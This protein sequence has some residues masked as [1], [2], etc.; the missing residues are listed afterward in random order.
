MSKIDTIGEYYG[1]KVESAEI[2]DNRLNITFDDGVDI[3][4]WDNG[5]SCCEERYIT[6]DDDVSSLVGGVLTDISVSD[7]TESGGDYDVHEIA[8]VKVV[9]DRFAITL[10]THNIHNGYYGGFGLTITENK[11]K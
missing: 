2:K 5:Q 6:C 10:T 8:F 11:G 4:L 9:T 1:K 3:S 7:V